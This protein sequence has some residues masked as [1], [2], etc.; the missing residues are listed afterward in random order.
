MQYAGCL[1]QRTFMQV[2]VTD[3]GADADGRSTLALLTCPSLPL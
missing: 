3:L 1:A 2:N